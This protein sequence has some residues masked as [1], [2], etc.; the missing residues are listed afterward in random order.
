MLN[1]ST[2]YNSDPQLTKFLNTYTDKRYVLCVGKS[3]FNKD[4]FNFS[5]FEQ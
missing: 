1:Y 2:F 3:E 5:L 4:I